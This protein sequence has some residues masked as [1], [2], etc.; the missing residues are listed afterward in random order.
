MSLAEMR[1]NGVRSLAVRCEVCH[2]DALVN[3]DAFDVTVPKQ[4]FEP[5]MVCT[6]SG[7]VGAH[8]RP[9]WDKRPAQES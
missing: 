9:N 5:R 2:H 1:H 4:A 6:S 8:A 7:I 3:L